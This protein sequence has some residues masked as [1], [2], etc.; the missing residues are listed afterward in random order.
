[1][2]YALTVAMILFS[3]AECLPAKTLIED[4]DIFFSKEGLT[5]HTLRYSNILIQYNLDKVET[6][7]QKIQDALRKYHKDVGSNCMPL[8]MY[9]TGRSTGF[10]DNLTIHAAKINRHRFDYIFTAHLDRLAKFRGLIS[11]TKD[12]VE[13]HAL[14]H[15]TESRDFYFS[16][17][18]PA[19]ISSRSQRKL[20]NHDDHDPSYLGGNKDAASDPIKWY[21]RKQGKH[22]AFSGIMMIRKKRSKIP[23]FDDIFN[24]NYRL[25][26]TNKD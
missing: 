19:G 15:L 13:N 1:M 16:G 4:S 7:I 2:S 22:N 23:S 21:H 6:N 10:V 12:E 20:F 26:R 3:A 24:A 5:S 18:R 17:K 9:H 14:P 25:Y 8:T 11:E